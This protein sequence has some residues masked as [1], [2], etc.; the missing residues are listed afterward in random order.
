MITNCTPLPGNPE[1]Q[2]KSP[3]YPIINPGLPV[4]CQCSPGTESRSPQSLR[5]SLVLHLYPQGDQTTF[6]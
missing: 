6:P 1:M 3:E 2:E 4:P 5:S